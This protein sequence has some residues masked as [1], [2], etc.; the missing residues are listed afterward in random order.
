MNHSIGSEIVTEFGEIGNMDYAQTY[1][2]RSKYRPLLLDRL[3]DIL[4]AYSPDIVITHGSNGE[5]GHYLHLITNL[6]VR[7]AMSL[8]D[9][10][11]SALFMTGMPEYNIDDHITHFLELDEATT[12]NDKWEAVRSIP[13]IYQPDRDFDKPWDPAKYPNGTFVKDYG[14][15]PVEAK[16]PKYEFF[17]IVGQ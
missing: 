8:T 12:L 13:E 15:S 1:G 3:L 17:K 11:C 5:Y 6:V 16:P 9:I 2:P 14:Y 4:S 10:Y 7:Q